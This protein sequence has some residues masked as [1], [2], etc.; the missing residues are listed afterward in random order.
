MVEMVYWVTCPVCRRAAGLGLGHPT[1]ARPPKV[2]QNVSNM[3]LVYVDTQ[4]EGM[5]DEFT[6]ILSNFQKEE[7]IVT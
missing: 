3:Q 1:R 2:A 5:Q 6:R 4:G 7:Y